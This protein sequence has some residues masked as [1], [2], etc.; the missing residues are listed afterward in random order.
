MRFQTRSL[1]RRVTGLLFA[2]ALA[3]SPARAADAP[4]LRVLAAASLTEVVEAIVPAFGG[5]PVEAVFGA[6]SALARQ[7]RDGAPAD[8]FLSAGPDWIDL[9]REAGALSG[10]PVVIARNRLVCVAPE[11]SPL[12]ADGGVA[13]PR[14]LL[15]RIARNGLVAVADPGVPA[16]EYARAA[17]ERLGLLAAYE[18][19]LVGQKDVRA[20]L[21]AVERGELDAGFV[22]ATDARVAAVV[23]LFAFDPATHPPV[24]YRAAALRAAADPGA[25]RRFLD[26]LGGEA[27]R[28][29]LAEAGFDLP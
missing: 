7:I 25:A 24:E 12:A 8:V 22:Y 10:D 2:A 16:G 13:D 26:F 20:V 23:T 1:R 21:H 17:L 29:V 3:A 15:E 6:S 11:G 28:A 27:A 4:P 18:R 19:R 5:G 14:A 9:L